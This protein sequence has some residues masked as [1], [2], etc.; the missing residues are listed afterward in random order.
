MESATASVL[1]ASLER[2]WEA[3]VARHA[4]IPP[5]VIVVAPGQGRA[6]DG[7]KLGHFAASRWDVAGSER[8]EVL[9]GGEGLR[10][11]P[12]ELLGTLLHEAAHGLGFARS[13]R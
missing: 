10:L 7:I 9:V 5:A 2:A 13:V 11:G 6:R 1:V 12:E 4:E 8:A 3:I